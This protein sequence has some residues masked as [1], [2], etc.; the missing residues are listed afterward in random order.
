[1]RKLCTINNSAKGSPFDMY[2]SS[3]CLGCDAVS[4][5]GLQ[6]P[7]DTK[8]DVAEDL[9]LH[10]HRYEELKPHNHCLHRK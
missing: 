7:S 5:G 9:N 6:P 8:N 10:Y 1:M 2:Q 3:S 4:L